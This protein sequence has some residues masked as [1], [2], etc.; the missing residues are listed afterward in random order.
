MAQAA[1][2]SPGALCV[3]PL[4]GLHMPPRPSSGASCRARLLGTCLARRRQSRALGAGAARV[5]RVLGGLCRTR[6][7]VRA[8]PARAEAAPAAAQAPL[9]LGGALA[10]LLRAGGGRRVRH[11]AGVGGGGAH[12]AARRAAEGPHARQGWVG[13]LSAASKAARLLRQQFSVVGRQCSARCRRW[14][15]LHLFWR[16]PRP[17]ACTHLAV[18]WDRLRSMGLLWPATVLVSALPVSGSV[19]AGFLSFVP[20]WWSPCWHRPIASL[21]RG[22][23]T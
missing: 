21:P 6:A 15:L 18:A 9:P 20:A 3:T 12:H 5:S 19:Q 16:L 17:S 10:G 14:R 4:L 1:R 7:R 23:M 11:A 13:I 8:A 2:P 22:R